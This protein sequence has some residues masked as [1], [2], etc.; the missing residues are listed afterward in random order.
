MRVERARSELSL[1]LSRQPNVTEI[2]A[3]V[4]ADEEDVVEALE[5][6]SAYRATSLDAP[7]GKNDDDPTLGDTLG[8]DE[9]GFT[10]AEQRTML[11][12][13]MR[14]L[15]PRERI[16]LNLRFTHDLTQLEIGERIG[17]SQMQVSRILRQALARLREHAAAFDDT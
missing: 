9:R 8:T 13:L 10:R 3:D 17:I 5:A 16:V 11:K 14:V 7:R 12:Q 2:A 1:T 15:T 4:G 6:F